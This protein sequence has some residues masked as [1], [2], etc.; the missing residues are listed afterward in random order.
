VAAFYE[1]TRRDLQA[2]E[3]GAEADS[4]DGVWLGHEREVE[5]TAIARPG[6]AARQARPKSSVEERKGCD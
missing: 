4:S 3:V 5:D 1:D 2:K 6:V